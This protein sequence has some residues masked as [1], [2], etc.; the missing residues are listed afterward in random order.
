M[1]S[2]IYTINKDISPASGAPCAFGG[3][4]VFSGFGY[5]SGGNP[6]LQIAFSNVGNIEIRTKWWTTGFTEWC[7]IYKVE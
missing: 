3:L 1:K 7:T 5:G 6:I 4:I 2:G